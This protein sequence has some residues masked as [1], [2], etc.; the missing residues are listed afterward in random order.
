MVQIVCL[1]RFLARQPYTVQ[2]LYG[3]DFSNPPEG[4]EKRP[5]WDTSS[6]NSRRLRVP[7]LSRRIDQREFQS[8]SIVELQRRTL[9]SR[10]WPGKKY[11]FLFSLHTFCSKDQRKA[12]G[13]IFNRCSFLLMDIN[14]FFNNYFAAVAF[15]QI[16]LSDRIGQKNQQI[17]NAAKN[18]KR[19]GW[20]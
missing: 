17:W 6:T 1:G 14:K 13:N 8:M 18:E 4:R 7:T 2:Y 5:T 16:S 19:V 10:M 15:L 3:G 9:L 12:M 20:W 11:D